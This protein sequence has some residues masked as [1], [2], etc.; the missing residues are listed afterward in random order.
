MIVMVEDLVTPLESEVLI[1]PEYIL[2][3]SFPLSSVV[4]ISPRAMVHPADE[5]PIVM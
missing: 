5:A 1:H 3:A 4:E 2:S